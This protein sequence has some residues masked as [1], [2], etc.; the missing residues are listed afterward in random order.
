L[1]FFQGDA[2]VKLTTLHSFK[3]WETRALVV[4]I[5][6]AKSAE[7]LSLV[8]AGITRLKTTDAGSYLT[9]INTTQELA[10][11]GKKWPNHRLYNVIKS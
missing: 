1:A 8:Y 2:R 5:S 6:T 4:Q 11:Y 10:E 3:G 7:A 9:V